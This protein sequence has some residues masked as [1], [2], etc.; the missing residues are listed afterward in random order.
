[1]KTNSFLIGHKELLFFWT[2]ESFHLPLAT[3]RVGQLLGIGW[4]KGPPGS[5]EYSFPLA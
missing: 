2:S 3:E 4:S 5:R 1:M